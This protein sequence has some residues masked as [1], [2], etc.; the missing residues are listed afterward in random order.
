[1]AISR[2]HIATGNRPASTGAIVIAA[3]IR[4]SGR[5]GNDVSVQRWATQLELLGHRVTV[6]P[7]EEGAKLNSAAARELDRA[8]LLLALHA[9]RSA[10]MVQWWGERHPGLPLIVALSG[11]DLYNDMPDSTEAMASA[12]AADALIVLQPAALERLDRLA[13]GWGSKTTVVHQSVAPPLPDRRPAPDEVRVIV[14]A[15]LRE[16]KDPLLAARAARR[17]DQTSR[18]TVH[19]AGRAFD[20]SWVEAAE[21]EEKVNPRYHWHRELDRDAALRLLAT[22]HVLACTSLAEGGANVVTEAI[23]VGVPVIGTRIE[24]HTGLLGADHPGLIPVGDE[25]AL[26]DLLTQLEHDRPLLDELRRRT[27]QLRPITEPAAERLA[28]ASVIAAAI[29]NA[30]RSP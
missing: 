9:R 24:G 10:P 27:D 14:L 25:L 16:V 19:H 1:M 17:L 3:P 15:H 6:L 2:G 30:G 22:G 26:T 20:R 7:V 28:L 29:P 5:S 11:T 13:P 18:V 12:D 8:D 23:A 21:N 4:P